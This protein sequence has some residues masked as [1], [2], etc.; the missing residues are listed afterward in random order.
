LGYFLV[1][2]RHQNCEHDGLTFQPHYLSR[3]LAGVIILSL[4][5]VFMA[6]S[7][8]RKTRIR[9]ILIIIIIATIPCYL[10]GIVALKVG[11]QVQT[12]AQTATPTLTLTQTPPPAAT[13]ITPTEF[14]TRTPTVTSTATVTWTPSVTY[15][16]FIP[17]TRTETPTPPPTNTPTETSIPSQT[18]TEEPVSTSTPV[19][20]STLPPTQGAPSINSNPTMPAVSLILVPAFTNSNP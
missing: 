6:S 1:N 8:D 17:P 9:S 20:E 5:G 10:V 3:V 4:S 12:G 19:P 14:V 7:V 11:Q 16:P 15:T 2:R 18:P 13:E